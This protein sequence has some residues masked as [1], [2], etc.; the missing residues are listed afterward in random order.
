MVKM[1][2]LLIAILIFIYCE[3][4]LYLFNNHEAGEVMLGMMFIISFPIWFLPLVICEAIGGQNLSFL[5][6]FL[7]D[8][9]FWFL[10]AAFGY[11]QWFV[12][13][14]WLIEWSKEIFSKKKNTQN[15]DGS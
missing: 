6:Q 13:I 7:G 5:P 14:P 8:L 10:F 1:T 2:W 4:Q 9:V 3:C 12:A 11:F 15:A